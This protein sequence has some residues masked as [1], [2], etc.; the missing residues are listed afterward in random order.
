MNVR[1]PDHE[2]L[3]SGPDLGTEQESKIEVRDPVCGAVLDV[4]D[5]AACEERDG[6]AY[7]FCSDDCRRAFAGEPAPPGTASEIGAAALPGPER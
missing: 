4:G 3:S 7:F 5:A 1:I 2:E 6:W